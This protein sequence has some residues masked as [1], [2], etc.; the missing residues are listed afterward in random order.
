MIT[1]ITLNPAIDLTL[2]IKQFNED[3]SNR[4]TSS[5]KDP[6]GKGINVSRIVKSLG[7]SPITLA[8]LGGFAGEELGNLM[9]K[10]NIYIWSVNTKQ[11]TR[12]NITITTADGKQTRLNQRG[13]QVSQAEFREMLKMVDVIA[14][15]SSFLVLSGSL[16]PGLNS[17]AY[18]QM[19]K[20]AKRS[21]SDI[22][23]VLDCDG[24]TFNEGL[25]GKPFIVKPNVHETERIL[26]LKINNEKELISAARKL[27]QKGAQNVTISRGAKGIIALTSNGEL[28]KVTPPKVKVE[29]TV[30]AGDSFIAGLILALHKGKS[31]DNALIN[32]VATSSAMVQTSGTQI[33]RL[34][35]CQSLTS[36]V[37]LEKLK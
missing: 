15:N 6:G 7:D 3:D 12:T 27:Q 14:D 22:K 1:T 35:D 13:P 18:L 9:R 31:F 2:N 34:K 25:K 30:G 10:E 26:N 16:S 37:K 33:P 23:I 21:N 17:D 8:M 24:K 36:K 5:R 4:V 19:I 11:E 32:G 29:S 20:R 28:Y